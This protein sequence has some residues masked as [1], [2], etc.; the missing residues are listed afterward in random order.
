M[1][2]IIDTLDS[3][4]RAHPVLFE[5]WCWAL[6]VPV[7]CAAAAFCWRRWR[8][9]VASRPV[10]EILALLYGYTA[11]WVL[12]LFVPLFVFCTYLAP[13]VLDR[14]P[15]TRSVLQ[16]LL[17]I[18][19]WLA[20]ALPLL[21]LCWTAVVISFFW[22]NLRRMSKPSSDEQTSGAVPGQ[23]QRRRAR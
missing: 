16:P 15:A 14:F 6:G 11:L 2:A 18:S 10:R 13:A 23:A 3:L 20:V 4:G 21:P 7:L 5:L 22:R 12:G 8:A 17:E 19:H 9:R 1:G